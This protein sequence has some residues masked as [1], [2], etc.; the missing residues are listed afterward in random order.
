MSLTIGS[1]WF[2]WDAF[3]FTDLIIPLTNSTPSKQQTT[4]E[5]PKLST[6]LTTGLCA[7][8]PS[9][10]R[11][12]LAFPG[13]SPGHIQLVDL[14]PPNTTTDTTPPHQHLPTNISLITAHENRL[15]CLA[16]NNSGTLLASA[17][18]HGTL[19]RIWDTRS[20]ACL[21]EL[22][23]GVDRATI[24]SIAFSPPGPPLS[25]S[26]PPETLA[27]ENSVA[28]I[29]DKGTIHIFSLATLTSPNDER[30]KQS[31]LTPLLPLLPRYFQSRW[32]FAKGIVPVEGGDVF[33]LGW[34]GEGEGVVVLGRSGWWRFSVPKSFG[35]G[36]GVC[37]EVGYKRYLGIGSEG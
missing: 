29:S 37:R 23:R 3:M 31:S 9:P 7:L 36:E 11:S 24:H 12:L 22:R 27:A 5:V 20:C 33:R 32:G 18:T 25:A 13:R 19:L 1:W 6:Y 10:T 17:S 4:T 35:E 2:S 14:T 34:W 16:I 30:N 15:A 28:T 26:S 21:T 8:S